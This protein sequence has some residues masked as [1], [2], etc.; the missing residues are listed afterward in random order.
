M[1]IDYASFDAL[2]FDCY[3]TLID[4]EAGM[5][6]AFRPILS[7]HGVTA[8]DEDVLVRYARYE[9]AAEAGPYRR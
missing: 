1:T 7:A 9:A 8:D 2:T 3:G 4:W 6:A 5:T